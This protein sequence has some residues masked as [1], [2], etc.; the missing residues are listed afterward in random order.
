LQIM[1]S[2]KFLRNEASVSNLHTN[3]V[4]HHQNFDG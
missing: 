4:K 3:E 1:P 2:K